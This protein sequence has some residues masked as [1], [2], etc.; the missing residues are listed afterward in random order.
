MRVVLVAAIWLAA[1]TA[2]ALAQPLAPLPA[3]PAGLAWPT[4]TWPTGAAEGVDGQALHA[5]V[6]RVMARPDPILGETRAVVAIQSGRLVYERYAPGYTAASR[7]VSW[8]AA[9][10][11]THAL[12]G[13]AAR[14]G[15]LNP[16]AA[17]GDPAWTGGQGFSE[18]TWRQWLMMVDGQD[19]LEVGSRSVV[20][21]GSA[22]ALFGEGRTDVGGFC[23]RRPV[24]AAPGARWNYNTCGITLVATALGRLIAPSGTVDARR[25]AF[26]AWMRE[27]LFAPIGMRSAI[28]EF[29]AQGAFLGGS[30][31][32]ATAHDFARF[33]Y[34]YLRDG[35]WDGQRILPQ[36]WVDFARFPQ[37]AP[38]TDT[39]GA[40][41]WITPPTGDGKG[42]RSLIIGEGMR[43]AFSAQGRSG[44]VV[45]IVPSKDLVLVRLGQFAQDN[46]GA[47]NALGDW[48]GGVARLFPDRPT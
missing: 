4:Q 20:E 11:I 8:S 43:D 38:E 35:L 29:D 34:L 21:N 3:H 41:F 7:H 31:L 42:M 39:Y 37:P 17:M 12:V 16:D 24:K 13:V 28:P 27:A 40:G 23:A 1:A 18:V 14:Q 30:L 5:A 6:D 2:G 46:G 47:W 26:S 22:R 25:A 44:Q 45:L 19:W 32:Y 10:S 15:R 33:G 36:G 9:K 48:M